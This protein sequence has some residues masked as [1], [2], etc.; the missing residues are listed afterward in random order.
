MGCTVV[1][2]GL[3]NMLAQ[4]G[5]KREDRSSDGGDVVGAR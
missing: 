4:C 1:A 5:W 3:G 2:Y